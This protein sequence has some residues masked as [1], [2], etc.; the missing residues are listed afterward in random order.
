MW[1]NLFHLVTCSA[2]ASQMMN[3]FTFYN[4]K[5]ITKDE[6]YFELFQEIDDPSFEALTQECLEIICCTCS[7]MVQSQL[8]G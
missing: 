7:V 5:L 1:E 4:K 6:I 3:S 8:K 2:D